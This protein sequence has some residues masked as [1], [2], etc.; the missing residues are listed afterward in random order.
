MTACGVVGAGAVGLGLVESLLRGGFAVGVY[1]LD[2]GALVATD[3]CMTSEF[4]SAFGTF[5]CLVLENQCSICF[6]DRLVAAASSSFSFS[7]G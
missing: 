6:F 7:V 2:G 5:R 3:C 4:V 1:D